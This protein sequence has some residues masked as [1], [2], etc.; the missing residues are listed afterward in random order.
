MIAFHKLARP[1]ALS[2][3]GVVTA[4]TFAVVSNAAQTVT[5]PNAA[6]ITY[7]LAAGA[8]SPPFTPV[9]G[10]PVF[11]MGVNTT[12]FN[13]GVGH[14]SLLR[15]GI[16]PTFLEWTGVESPSPAALTSGFSGVPGTHIVFID[17]NHQLDIEVATPDSIQ[18]HNSNISL[19]AGNVT[20][21]W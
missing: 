1:A 19:Q 3:A 18:I 7:S 17:F 11:V 15:S 20:L 2:L 21:I 5:M 4:L 13:R 6:V 14:V 9:F 8:V 12:I 10:R 16:A